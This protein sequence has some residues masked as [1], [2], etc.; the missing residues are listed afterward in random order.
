MVH[1]HLTE[2][3][4]TWAQVN[5]HRNQQRAE[6]ELH[7]VDR[8]VHGYSQGYLGLIFIFLSCFHKNMVLTFMM[9]FQIKSGVNKI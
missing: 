2:K 1:Y 9:G 3:T 6:L 4:L 7:L 8:M 5:D